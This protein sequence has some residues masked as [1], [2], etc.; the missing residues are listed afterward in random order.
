MVE[1]FAKLVKFIF[2]RH[3]FFGRSLNDIIEW[4]NVAF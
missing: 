1:I 4:S 3:S 2:V